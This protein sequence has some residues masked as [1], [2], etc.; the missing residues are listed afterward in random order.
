[1]DQEKAPEAVA[2]A[3]EVA[4]AAASNAPAAA[5]AAAPA[6]IK[7]AGK[8][9]VIAI[10]CSI[11]GVVIA[12]AVVIIILV[13]NNS[14]K[15]YCE[16][17]GENVTFAFNN[18]NIV[19]LTWVGSGMN[20]SLEEIQEDFK[21]S[22]MSTYDYMKLVG[23][24]LTRTGAKCTLK[25]EEIK[26]E[27]NAFDFDFDDEEEDDDEDEED[28][29]FDFDDEEEDED[30]YSSEKK[31]SSAN[32]SSCGSAEE[33]INSLSIEDGVTVAD[34]NKAIGFEGTLDTDGYQSESTKTYIWKFDNGDELSAE[35]SSYGGVEIEVEYNRSAHAGNGN[36]EGYSSIEDRIKSGVSYDELKA[37]LGGKDGL[38]SAKSDYSTK[39]IWIGS[40][41]KKY[42]EARINSSTN[43]VSSVFGQK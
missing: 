39:R 1:M 28:Y 36:I 43:Q 40:D 9:K 32:L 21:S 17:G 22:K 2:P 13:M 10:V 33:C 5:P 29:D 8:G 20:T 27:S 30:D 35:F 11:V 24:Q 18:D 14:D 12:A 41:S 26:A 34:Y 6:P 25:G 23:Q 37:A 15:L 3:P 7:K 4:P 42:I 31:P 38:L 19:G 16:R